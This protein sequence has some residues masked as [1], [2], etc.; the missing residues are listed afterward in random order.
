M[1]EETYEIES[2]VDSEATTVSNIS[3]SGMNACWI[4]YLF[5]PW[6]TK[7]FDFR[8][9]ISVKGP[10]SSSIQSDSSEHYKETKKII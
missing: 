8:V 9:S 10:T 3:D 1:T 7:D 4:E 2:V 6:L 5:A